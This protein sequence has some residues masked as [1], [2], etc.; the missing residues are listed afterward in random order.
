MKF[1]LSIILVFIFSLGIIDVSHSKTFKD[2][3]DREVVIEN[4]PVRIIPLAPSLTEILYYLGLGDRVA[5]VT[6]YSYYPPE[7][8]DE[9]ADRVIQ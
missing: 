4:N 3:V 1:I 7:A 9:T 8:L 6:S 5:G 2:A